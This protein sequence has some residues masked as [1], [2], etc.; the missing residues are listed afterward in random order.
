MM[1]KDKELHFTDIVSGETFE[2]CVFL[3]ANDLIRISEVSF[4]DCTFEQSDFTSS[5]WLDCTFKRVNFVNCHFE[6]SIVYRTK[7]L[8]CNLLGVDFSTNS[9]KNNQIT[10]CRVDYAN[11][12]DSKLIKCVVKD[13]SFKETY[14]RYV[15]FK[16]GFTATHCNFDGVSFLGSKLAKVD[17][18]TSE[19]ETLEVFSE[20]LEGIIINQFQASTLIGVLGVIVK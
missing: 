17:L 16:T 3:K 7:F 2:N 13:S 12:S 6:K 20:D 18:S 15:E 14:F 9:W 10:D 8:T 5:E 19:F 1:I 4:I 11:F